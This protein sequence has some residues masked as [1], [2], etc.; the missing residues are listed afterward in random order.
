M[1]DHAP[2]DPVLEILPCEA[3]AKRQQPASSRRSRHPDAR[4]CTR[5]VLGVQVL[6]VYFGTPSMFVTL[7]FGFDYGTNPT[8]GTLIK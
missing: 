7:S 1:G 8:L 6:T 3:A 5:P 2:L 4:R